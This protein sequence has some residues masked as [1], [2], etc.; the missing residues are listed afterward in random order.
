M[1]KY[2][3]WSASSP[4]RKRVG[5][6]K[7]LQGALHYLLRKGNYCVVLSYLRNKETKIRWKLII[8]MTVSSVR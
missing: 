7:F 8:R 2:K 4:K 6:G 5:Q 3:N 1:Y